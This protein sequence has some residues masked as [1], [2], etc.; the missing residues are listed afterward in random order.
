[1]PFIYWRKK[2]E[3]KNTKKRIL[4]KGVGWRVGIRKEI[5]REKKKSCNKRKRAKEQKL[6]K[7]REKNIRSNVIYSLKYIL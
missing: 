7:V 4:K 1:M 2:K 6:T 3:K 5:S